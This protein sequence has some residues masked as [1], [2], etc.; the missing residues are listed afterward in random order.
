[1]PFFQQ[2]FNKLQHSSKTS[3]PELYS[4]AEAVHLE[5]FR[6]DFHDVFDRD[7]VLVL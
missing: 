6:V 2:N 4:G 1:M 7:V 5:R 3:A